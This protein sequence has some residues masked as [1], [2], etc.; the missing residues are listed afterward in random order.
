M[1]VLE[2]QLGELSLGNAGNLSV[3]SHGCEGEDRLVAQQ[4][5]DVVEVASDVEVLEERKLLYVVVGRSRIL[6]FLGVDVVLVV[7]PG[8]H[9][10]E[11][12]NFTFGHEV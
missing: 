5:A 3:V 12:S 1:L 9:V 10:H 11:D 6:R 2:A 8:V 4:G 7:L